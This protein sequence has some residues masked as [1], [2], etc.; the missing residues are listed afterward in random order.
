MNLRLVAPRRLSN[1]QVASCSSHFRTRRRDPV[2]KPAVLVFAASTF[3]R[4]NSVPPRPH[5]NSDAELPRQKSCCTASRVHR[6]RGQAHLIRDSHPEDHA[7]AAVAAWCGAKRDRGG[8]PRRRARRVRTRLPLGPAHPAVDGS[9]APAQ[10]CERPPFASS[11]SERR[12]TTPQAQGLLG[13]GRKR[14]SIVSFHA[15]EDEHSFRTDVNYL[16]LRLV[17]VCYTSSWEVKNGNPSLMAWA[18]WNDLFS[19]H[20]LPR[21]FS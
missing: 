13:L 14:A 12:F 2:R 15:R 20:F 1:G 19:S 10:R 21:S 18:R 3:R 7:P 16:M 5:R 6:A 17:G 8:R 4:A 11:H 9:P